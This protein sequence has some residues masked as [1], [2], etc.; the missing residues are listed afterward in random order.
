MNIYGMYFSPTHGTEK[1]V[2]HIMMGLASGLSEG[3]AG[4]IN[5]TPHESRE[6]DAIFGPGDILIIGVP[7]YAGRVP[8]KI[9]PYLRDSIEGTGALCIP[10]VTYGNR[11]YDDSL[12]E[13]SLLMDKNGF[14]VIAA[15][16]FLC[17]HSFTEKLATGRPTK[18]DLNCATNF[19][20]EIAGALI[21]DENLSLDIASLP[22]RSLEE[23][24]YYVPK[25]TDGKAAEFL[26]V[27]PHTYEDKCIECGLCQKI[28]PMNCFSE[29]VKTATGTC[30]KCMACVT[31]CPQKAKYFDAE[32]FTG[33]REMLEGNYA[34]VHR[35]IETFIHKKIEN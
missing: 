18:E 9:M 2:Q 7:T 5:I 1:V 34:D 8:N 3:A 4:C 28:C 35:E 10:V 23:M 26:K 31:D 24:A 32:D 13:L 11:A 30:I 15:G 22:G 17:Q 6:E 29:G 27:K 16:V 14:K 20:M 33:H 12:K 19:G 21:E 25:K